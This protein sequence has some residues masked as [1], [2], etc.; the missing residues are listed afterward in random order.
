MRVEKNA[1]RLFYHTSGV[2]SSAFK[3]KDNGLKL[4]HFLQNIS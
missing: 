2:V 3:I 1:T 4:H